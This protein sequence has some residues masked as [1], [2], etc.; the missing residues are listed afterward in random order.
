MYVLVHI[1]YVLFKHCSHLS[2]LVQRD[3]IFFLARLFFF[4]LGFSVSVII[5]FSNFLQNCEVPL[6][7]FIYLISSIGS[8]CFPGA[9]APG[10]PNSLI[11]IW[12]HCFS[13][14]LHCNPWV[15]LHSH[16]WNAIVL[17][18]S[19]FWFLCLL[20]S[21]VWKW[22]LLSCVQ[23]FAMPWTMMPWTTQSMEFSRPEYY[24]GEAFP[25]PGDLP[26]PR[27]E[28]RYPALQADSLPSEPPGKTKNTGIGSL[29]LLQRIFPTQESN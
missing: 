22:K 8:F 15:S 16:F 4:C 18:P 17:R 5:S 12:M 20:F 7:V 23:L 29:S 21:L 27:I 25:S 24:S 2:S 14:L 1:I 11:L 19:V 6:C 13:C 10:I 9:I 3:Y 28:C 26:N